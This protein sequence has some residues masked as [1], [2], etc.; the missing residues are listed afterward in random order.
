MV[1]YELH[2][3]VQV[4]ADDG[5]GVLLH[6]AHHIAASCTH[7]PIRDKHMEKGREIGGKKEGLILKEGERLT[8]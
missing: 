3:D 8:D 1:E 2:I 4:P 7:H 5:V 6:V